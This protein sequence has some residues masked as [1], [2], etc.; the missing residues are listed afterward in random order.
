MIV[1]SLKKN[2]ALIHRALHLAFAHQLKEELREETISPARFKEALATAIDVFKVSAEDIRNKFGVTAATVSRWRNGEATP[3]E[4]IRVSVV[5]W[6]A[7]EIE[8]MIKDHRDESIKV[9]KQAAT[10]AKTINL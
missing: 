1:P 2:A 4:F 5:S 3:G 10:I 9:A 7:D 8:S 6:L